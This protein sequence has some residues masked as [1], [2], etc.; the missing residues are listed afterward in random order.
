[1]ERESYKDR[2]CYEESYKDRYCYEVRGSVVF[3]KN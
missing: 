3:G 1:M 2:Y